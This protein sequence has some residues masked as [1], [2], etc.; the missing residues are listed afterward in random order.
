MVGIL[1]IKI[2]KTKNIEGIT[3][4]NTESRAD[5]FADDTTFSMSQKEDNLGYA[6]KYLNNFHTISGLACNLDKTH[7][8]PV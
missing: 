2:T 5:A 4:V 8:I 1:L 7:T 6:T 3:Y